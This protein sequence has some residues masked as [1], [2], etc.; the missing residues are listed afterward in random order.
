MRSDKFA[1]DGPR[2][3]SEVKSSI[4]KLR[5]VERWPSTPS[6]FI[7]SWVMARRC[8]REPRFVFASKEKKKEKR[9][10]AKRGGA[11]RIEVEQEDEKLKL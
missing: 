7:S 4:I 9:N 2:I 3:E 8:R 11:K 10:E 5:S 1:C 6:K